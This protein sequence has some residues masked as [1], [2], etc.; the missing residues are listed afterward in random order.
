MQSC[1]LHITTEYQNCAAVYG[2]L[3]YTHTDSDV[4]YTMHAYSSQSHPSCIGMSPLGNGVFH[5]QNCRM[6]SLHS[7]GVLRT[8]CQPER[9]D[10]SYHQFDCGSYAAVTEIKKHSEICQAHSDFQH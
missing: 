1:R 8:S 4:L 10:I 5:L 7:Q 2:C 6:A 3:L 9:V